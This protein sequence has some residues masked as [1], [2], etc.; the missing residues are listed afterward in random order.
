[1]ESAAMTTENLRNTMAT[2]DAMKQANV[3]MKRQYG[4][5]D[6]DK[7]EQIHYDMEDMIEQANEIQESLGRSYGVP[8]EIDEDDLQAELD[9]LET[10][11]EDET[12]SYLQDLNATPDFIDEAPISEPKMNSYKNLKYVIKDN[13]ASDDLDKMHTQ[14]VH[15]PRAGQSKLL[16]EGGSQA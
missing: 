15:P 1:M 5:I 6:V 12:P 9:A 4:K 11:E 8:D 16:R 13:H 2:L 7:I 10:L 3:E 14:L